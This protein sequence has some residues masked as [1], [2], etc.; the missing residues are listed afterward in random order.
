MSHGVT[1]ALEFLSTGASSVRTLTEARAVTATA[2]PRVGLVVDSFHFFAGASTWG[3]LDDLEPEAVALVRLNDAENRPLEDLTESNRLLP[4]DGV[5]PMRELLRRVES[6]GYHGVYSIQ[7]SR[8]EYW[9]WKPQ[10]LAR[11][12]LESIESVCAEKDEQE[13]LL[14]YD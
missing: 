11:V 1:V 2:F 12:A 14:D 3:M 10:R 5:V 6:V 9:E 7:L 13:G 8:P 4:G